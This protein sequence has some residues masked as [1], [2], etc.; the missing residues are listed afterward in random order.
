MKDIN[1]D[2]VLLSRLKSDDKSFRDISKVMQKDHTAICSYLKRNCEVVVL[3][4]PKKKSE[5]KKLLL[6][7]LKDID[8]LIDCLKNI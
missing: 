3:Y 7:N 4:M 8:K 2:L 5:L 1:Y 6:D